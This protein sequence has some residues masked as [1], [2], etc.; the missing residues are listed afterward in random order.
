MRLLIGLSM[1]RRVPRKPRPKKIN[2]PKGYDSRWEY[3]IH[4]GI[5][6]DWKH[7][8]DVIQYVVEHKYE[9][10]FVKEFEKDFGRKPTSSLVAKTLS[11]LSSI[12]S[13]SICLI[14]F[15]LLY[16]NIRNLF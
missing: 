15:S 11:N 4:L 12:F 14:L 2:V 16:I 7:H 5:L 1:A 6:K 8:W 3:D 10:D 9:P 13:K